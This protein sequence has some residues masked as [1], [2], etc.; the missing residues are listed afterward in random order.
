MAMT[1]L[2]LQPAGV[3]RTT[4]FIWETGRYLSRK[5]HGLAGGALTFVFRFSSI[6]L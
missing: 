3:V 2:Q 5:L 4:D 6:V 1:T